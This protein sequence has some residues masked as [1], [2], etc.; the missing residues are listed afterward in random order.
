MRA[1]LLSC[2]NYYGF[3]AELRTEK[4]KMGRDAPALCNK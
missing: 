1:P 4:E 3:L 2:L